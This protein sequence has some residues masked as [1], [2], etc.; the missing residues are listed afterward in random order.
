PDTADWRKSVLPDSAS[1]RQGWAAGTVSAIGVDR[2]AIPSLPFFV[3]CDSTGRQI[4]RGSDMTRA[5]AL[6]D[7]LSSI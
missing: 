2:L 6:A 3:V 1:W 7:S 5:C 4:Y